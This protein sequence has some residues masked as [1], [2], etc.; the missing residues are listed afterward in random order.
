[1]VIISWQCFA[2]GLGDLAVHSYLDQPLD[3][4]I[5][6]IDADSTPLTD[7][8]VSIG[9]PEE[10]AHANLSRDEQALSLLTLKLKRKAGQLYVELRSTERME[11]PYLDLLID[12]AWPGGEIYRAYSV[13]LDP[14]HY[15]L[16]LSKETT[17]KSTRPIWMN[18]VV[19]E[20]QADT[21]TDHVTEGPSTYGP[22]LVNENIWQ[23][24]Q[25]YTETNL[26]LQQVML[27][28][29][30]HNPDA[31]TDGNVNGLKP[32]SRLLIPSQAEMKS[33]PASLARQEVN[34]QDSAWQTH[35]SI[36]HVLFPPYIQARDLT[37]T[38]PV[39]EYSII[40]GAP[41][42]E[43]L[44]FTSTLPEI[45][46]LALA[47]I[48]VQLPVFKENQALNEAS[49]ALEQRLKVLEKKNALLLKQLKLKEAE[50]RQWENRWRSIEQRLKQEDQMV[51]TEYPV[52]NT[53]I[54]KFLL[55]LGL[56]F[57]GYGLYWRSRQSTHQEV[58]QIPT[59]NN[60]SSE[61]KQ[62]MALVKNKAALDELLTLAKT[63]I[64]REEFAAA[65]HALEEVM[66]YGDDAQR[67][68]ASH[69]WEQCVK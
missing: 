5:R 2:I 12:L 39:N 54:W 32:A 28:I 23:I 18:H 14:V 31:F 25:R 46:E 43:E 19:I 66:A 67:N 59:P 36:Q 49:H 47:A 45:P 13:L 37:T 60:T 56:M 17:E 58:E 63:Y 61:R 3:A 35:T 27:A 51:T 65:K 50:L 57:I 20:R 21:E 1:M 53:W 68:E 30:G 8:K 41:V 55:V 7:I 69:L 33:I 62:A 52:A 26:T 29:L 48:G 34:Q 40:P 9:D 22:T 11:T 6:L 64:S 10:F 44:S 15:D 4:D 38:N 24:A 16:D 42:F